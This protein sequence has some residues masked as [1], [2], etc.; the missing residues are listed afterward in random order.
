MGGADSGAGKPDDLGGQGGT[1]PTGMTD[2]GAPRPVVSIPAGSFEM[3]CAPS[4]TQCFDGERPQHAVTLA[5][6][7]IDSAEVTQAAYQ[8]CIEG[9]ACTA[10]AA[11]FDP[12]HQGDYPVTRI[13]WT[14]AAAYCAFVRRRL[15][16]EA[17]WEKAARGV[18]ASIYP[19]GDGAPDCTLANYDACGQRA[20]MVAS[21]P[22]GASP[23][24]VLNM[25][26]NVAEWVADWFDYT[27]YSG[28]P[29]TDPKGPET[30]TF[31]VWRGGSFGSLP[32][33]LRAS[34]RSYAYPNVDSG[35]IGFRCA[36]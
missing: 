3:G 2:G 8:A 19:W 12:L 10:P 5:A 1:S 16:T 7:E 17:E 23:F 18:G 36:K 26:G 22:T 11:N 21:H 34:F 31:R 6:F 24:G 9:G 29:A 20:E 30:G 35:N 14:Q 33:D 15:P 32:Q 13:D 28:S 4:D 27:Y 25:A